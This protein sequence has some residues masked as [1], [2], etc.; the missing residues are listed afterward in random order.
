MSDKTIIKIRK[1]LDIR[2][3]GV[4]VGEVEELPSSGLYAV[5]TSG[6]VGLTPKLLVSEGD[7]V[8]AGDVLEALN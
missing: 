8:T 5:K 1:G 4:A 6:Q 7:R 3:P 2:I